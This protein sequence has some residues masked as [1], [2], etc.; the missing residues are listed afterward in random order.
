[1]LDKEFKANMLHDAY[2]GL[3]DAVLNLSRIS[4]DATAAP[5]LAEALVL[6]NKLQQAYEKAY[7][8]ADNLK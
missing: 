2:V 7:D 6:K 8:E 1:M 4:N 3:K 5:L